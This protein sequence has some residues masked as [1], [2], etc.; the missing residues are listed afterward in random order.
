MKHLT[1]ELRQIVGTW[2]E[3]T[4]AIPDDTFSEKPMPESWSNKEV[5]GHLVDSGQNNLRRFICGQYEEIPPKITYQQD[6]WVAANGYQRMNKADV[7]L[8]WKLVNLQ[9]CAVLDNMPKENYG[10]QC[11]TGALHS[12]EWLANDYVKHMN[13]HLNQIISGSY[14]VIYT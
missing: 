14:D 13:H 3:K 11:D 1:A 2:V 7:I 5:L 12:L 6:F 9:I 4:S 8:L 10:R